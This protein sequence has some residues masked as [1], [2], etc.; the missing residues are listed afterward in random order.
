M[1]VWPLWKRI[2]FRFLF[3]YFIVYLFPFPF[4]Y[5]PYV[6]DS[7]GA[8]WSAIWRALARPFVHG[9]A[10]TGP[11]GSGDGIWGYARVITFAA[12]AAL[13]TL[14]W[15]VLDRRRPNYVRLHQYL[16]AYLR[17]MLGVAMLDYGIRKVI[18]AQFPPLAL[19]RLVQTYG[20]SSPMGM[21]W[22]F[23]GASTAYIIFAGTMEVLGGLLLLFR[24]TALLGALVTIG[25]V[26]NIVALNF[27]YDVPVKL[28]S[29][30]LLATAVFLAA[31][32]LRKL[33][34]IFVLR[35]TEPLFH[36]RA[37]R[38]AVVALSM[39]TIVPSVYLAATESMAFVRKG[40]AARSPL[41]GIWNV[42]VLTS[43]ASRAR[44][45]L[46]IPRAGGDWSST[47]RAVRPFSS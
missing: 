24:R 44:R 19:D 1:T 7:L 12:I 5:V 8:G 40:K 25:V 31:P 21:L 32:D 37:L 20:S 11:N 33:L 47:F 3:V 26:T 46:P 35:P 10:A 34:D 4:D 6:G 38:V 36:T 14:I 9:V 28:Y 45:S 43:T 30:H 42:D 29:L 2:G 17:L 27:S 16:H 22:T 13:A 23:M 39:L 18:P 15:S 41:R